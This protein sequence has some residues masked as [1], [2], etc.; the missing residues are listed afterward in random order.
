VRA[1]RRIA[2]VAG[3]LLA[4]ALP[5]AA[6]AQEGPKTKDFTFESK[7]TAINPGATADPNDPTTFEDFPFTIKPGEVNGSINVHLEWLNPADDWDLYVYRKEGT[8]LQTV[9]QSAGGAPDTEEN[10]SVDG[11]GIPIRAGNYVI[12]V[13]N[14]ASTIPNFRGSARFG[15]FIPYNDAPVAKLS[16]PKRVK[17]GKKVRLDASESFDPDGSIKSYAFDLDGNGSMEVHNGTRPV[18]IRKLKPG[19]HHVAVRVKDSEGLRAFANRTIV[20]KKNK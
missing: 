17:Q 1:R 18:L 8:T 16:A 7:G 6:G 11:Q 20:V 10:A 12:R 14:Y 19:T 15:E 5:V 13:K 3:A 4:L 9:G 2:A